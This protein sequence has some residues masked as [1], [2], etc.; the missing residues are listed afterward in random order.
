MNKRE[1]NITKL[2]PLIG[3][4]EVES[5]HPRYSRR[6]S[7]HTSNFG[8]TRKLRRSLHLHIAINASVPPSLSAHASD[9][10]IYMSMMLLIVQSS[11]VTRMLESREAKYSKSEDEEDCHDHAKGSGDFIDHVKG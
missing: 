8:Q 10:G 1:R 2:D 3:V 5:A 9:P 6:T 4:G 7:A 11:V